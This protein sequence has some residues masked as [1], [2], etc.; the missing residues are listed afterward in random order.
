MVAPSWESFQRPN[1]QQVKPQQAARPSSMMQQEEDE[2]EKEYKQEVPGKIK[3]E[4]KPEAEKPQWGNFQS[5]TTYQG[6]PDPTADEGWLEYFLRGAARTTSRISEQALGAA[7]NVEK[8]IKDL[9]VNSPKYVAGPIIGAIA[10]Y[11]GQEKW[12][13][14]LT[15]G[16]P[17]Q[18][19]PTSS[20]LKE[21]SE[22]A[23]GGFTSP[24]TKNEARVDELIEDVSST[25]L[26]RRP[27]RSLA[28]VANHLLIPA[29]ANV[30]K[31]VVKELGFG[32]DK[33]NLA[34]MAIWLPLSLANNVNGARH[35]S[36][37]MN[38]GRN[39]FNQNQNVNVV[40]YQNQIA[41]VER[42]MLHADPRSALARAQIGGIEQDI[43]NGRTT[44]RDLM[45]R[46]DALNAAKRDRGLF[47]LGATDR[48]AAV[49]NINQVRDVLRDQI[50]AMGQSN[51]QALRDWQ[52]GVQAW[53]TIHQSRSITNWIQDT[54]KGAYAKILS[55]PVAALFGLGSYGA[56]HE[57]LVALSISAGTAAAYKTGQILYRIWNNPVLANY[58]W[59]AIGAANAHN[60]PT[61]MNNYEK[62]NNELKK[63]DSGSAQ[64]NSKR[65]K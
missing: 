30:T 64:E 17:R 55:G 50:T 40:N 58:Y 38:R 18:I 46:Y 42:T 60:L 51:P 65:K 7:G 33:A 25:L 1:Q 36:D 10:E 12:E 48:A 16:A 11:M 32:E 13:N 61:F 21:F 14:M 34:K 28:S 4:K 19:Y 31:G 8:T 56:A 43:A 9:I 53:A 62:L 59:N 3:D 35:A 22:K 52:N 26:T 2:Q 29:A 41:Q 6:E 20:T 23:T 54:A 57:P 15:A 27:T 39:G 5:P 45:T 24:K 37:L 44:M 47:E 49:R 63:S